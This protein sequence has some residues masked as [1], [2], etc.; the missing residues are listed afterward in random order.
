MVH[1]ASE[2]IAFEAGESIWTES[3]DKCDRETP[4]TIVTC[5]SFRITQLWTDAANRFWVAYLDAA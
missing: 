4:D 5:A 2:R 3:S 1:V